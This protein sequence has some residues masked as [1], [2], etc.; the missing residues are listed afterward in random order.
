MLRA[1]KHAKVALS[2]LSRTRAISRT[3]SNA[4]NGNDNGE[5]P[6]SADAVI[7]GGGVSGCS[8]LYHLAKLGM[9][10]V[11]LVEKDDITAGT[12]WHTAGLVWH[13]RPSDTE[14]QLLNY[15]WD[16]MRS[17]ED[18]TGVNTGYIE[19]GGLFIASTKTRLDEYQRM[20]SLGKVFG[21]E[22]Q[23]LSPKETKDLYPLMNVDHIYGTLYSPTDGTI[24]PNGYCSSLLRGATR[25]GSRYFTGVSVKDVETTEDAMGT[26]RVKSV[27]TSRGRIETPLLVNCAGA[28]APRLGQMAGVNVPLCA[29]RHAYVITDRIEGVQN[30]P[31]VR[32][33]DA[34]VYLRLQGDALSIGG[35]EKNPLFWEPEPNFAFSLFELDWDVFS[36]HIEGACQL[37]PAVE[38]AG[39]K[40]TVCGPESF[41]PDHKPLMGESPEL[42]GFVLNCGYN[43]AGMMLS[44]G[45]GR[46]MATWLVKGRPELDMFGYDIRRFN[47]ILT[48]N[49]EWIKQTSHEAYAKNYSVVYPH[50]EPLA[51]RNQ[52]KGALY[53]ELRDKGEI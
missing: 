26:R 52:I 6:T 20:G 11:V 51:G 23:V 40:S 18:E 33:H 2:P 49:R 7:V 48:S 44:G 1:V 16:L 9:T 36:V 50:D 3:L 12:T 17:L 41:T 5:F 45:C 42:R 32:D 4:T 35:Y 25:L 21:V 8:L 24:D 38:N 46:E 28:W 14:V 34:S 39:I 13:L 27:S 15:S 29:M 31:N 37:V 43:S 47:P 19:N 53:E 22:S 10:N 30:M